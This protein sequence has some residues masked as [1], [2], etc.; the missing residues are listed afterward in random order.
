MLE[1]PL[2]LDWRVCAGTVVGCAVVLMFS[3]IL[4]VEDRVF[5]LT[6]VAFAGFRAMVSHSRR[7]FRHGGWTLG[8]SFGRGFALRLLFVYWNWNTLYCLN[9]DL[10]RRCWWDSNIQQLPLN[11]LSTGSIVLTGQ[12]YCSW[13]RH[14]E[15]HITKFCRVLAAQSHG[16]ALSKAIADV[17]NS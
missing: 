4:V 3:A 6:T 10:F 12:G 7:L 14:Q 15:I 5:H 16:S 13:R 8:C 9:R 2:S 11:T 17:T 1:A